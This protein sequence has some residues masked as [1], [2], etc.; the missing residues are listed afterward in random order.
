[1]LMEF[2]AK[3]AYLELKNEYCLYCSCL[4]N[5]PKPRFAAMIVVFEN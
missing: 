5:P 4:S 2:F 1:M 3:S